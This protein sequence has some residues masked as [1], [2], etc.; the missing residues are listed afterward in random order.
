MESI[1]AVFWA[2]EKAVLP[3]VVPPIAAALAASRVTG[4]ASPVAVR[5]TGGETL[6]VDWAGEGDHMRDVILTGPTRL[7]YEGRMHI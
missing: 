2:D 1:M 3:F 7:V 6:E 4:A 5:T